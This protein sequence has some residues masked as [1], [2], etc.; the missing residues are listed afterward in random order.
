VTKLL[1]AGIV[2]PEERVAARQQLGKQVPA[3]TNTHAN[4]L[5]GAFKST[6]SK[7]ISQ[8]SLYFSE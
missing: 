7:V 5:L 8:A 1:K 2:E 6:E 4:K 3:A